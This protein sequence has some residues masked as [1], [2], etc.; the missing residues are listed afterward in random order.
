MTP[1]IQTDLHGA[2]RLTSESGVHDDQWLSGQGFVQEDV[3]AAVGSQSMLEV[4]PV[5]ERVHGLIGA[6]FLQQVAGRLPRDLVEL[7]QLRHE[8]LP[9]QL[10][11][12]NIHLLH[13][14]AGS[15]SLLHLSQSLLGTT[16][17]QG[18]NR[19]TRKGS[20]SSIVT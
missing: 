8:P 19:T 3:A 5:P 1:D 11:Q 14:H 10:L 16:H 15:T 4:L 6:D 2:G 7:Q 17:K 13:L 9:Q 18:T 20:S 12:T